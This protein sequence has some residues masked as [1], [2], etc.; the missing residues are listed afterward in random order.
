MWFFIQSQYNIMLQYPYKTRLQ[1][2][3]LRLLTP[4]IL[5]L[6][7]SDHSPKCWRS[8]LGRCEPLR[9]HYNMCSNTLDLI[10]RRRLHRSECSS[11]CYTSSMEHLKNKSSNKHEKS[12][13]ICK[14]NW[15][16][17]ITESF[18][19]EISSKLRKRDYYSFIMRFL[20]FLLQ[21]KHINI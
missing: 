16:Q 21:N 1:F 7:L 13:S 15:L 19:I 12:I 8:S 2:I 3:I 5:W 4:K 11:S 6:D 20:F 9:S 10:A 14:C 18:W 17:H